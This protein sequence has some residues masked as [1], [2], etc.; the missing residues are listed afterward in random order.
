MADLAGIKRT[1]H[2]LHWLWLRAGKGVII[3]DHCP[4]THRGLLGMNV[5]SACWGGAEKNN[6][7]RHSSPQR[8]NNGDTS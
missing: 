3:R 1:R 8:V 7:P 6:L 2:S 5:I 4:G